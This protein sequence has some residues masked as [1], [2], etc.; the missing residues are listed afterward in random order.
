MD[1]NLL[2]CTA[3]RQMG[4]QGEIAFKNDDFVYVTSLYL[5]FSRPLTCHVTIS[6]IPW[7]SN[8]TEDREAVDRHAAFQIGVVSD[9]VYTTGDW[10]KLMTD[11]LPPSILPRFTEQEKKDLLGL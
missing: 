8:S 7:R 4:I 5:Q 11:I 1:S 9:P 10:P 6:G 3:F 2:K